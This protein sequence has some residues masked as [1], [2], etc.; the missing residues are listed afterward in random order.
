MSS[1]LLPL[2]LP[3]F[4][5]TGRLLPKI[6]CLHLIF[7]P[8]A[9]RGDR[10]HHWE[11]Q[12]NRAGQGRASRCHGK[13]RLPV[14]CTQRKHAKVLWCVFWEETA[15]PSCLV[16]NLPPLQGRVLWAAKV[17]VFS[18][19]GEAGVV[20]CPLKADTCQGCPRSIL[21]NPSRAEVLHRAAR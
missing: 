11:S 5:P 8:W 9:D 17:K 7:S 6:Q 1:R 13:Q 4:F 14:L 10:S 18:I 21:W 16:R 19:R 20:L 2:L 12:Q 15:L 3:G